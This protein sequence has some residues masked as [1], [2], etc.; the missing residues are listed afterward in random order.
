M[1]RRFQRQG[2]HAA[3]RKGNTADFCIL[4]LCAGIVHPIQSDAI[5]K[6][7]LVLLTFLRQVYV[8]IA[9]G[10]VYGV[11]PHS[12][13]LLLPC[14]VIVFFCLLGGHAIR[15]FIGVLHL[16]RDNLFIIFFPR[17]SFRIK[18]FIRCIEDIELSLR[19]E[20]NIIA[21]L[22]REIC[23]AV[24][25]I[26]GTT[27]DFTADGLRSSRVVDFQQQAIVKP[28]AEFIV[29]VPAVEG[30]VETIQRIKFPILRLR[31]WL[32]SRCRVRGGGCQGGC[33][34]GSAARGEQCR[35]GKKNSG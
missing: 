20:R 4:G 11:Q 35:C 6:I 2:F 19:R 7:Y 3:V 14:A 32:R 30:G 17:H 5:A 18:K 24:L 33:V 34:G 16:R 23:R 8:G 9:S 26:M 15:R 31:G 21:G 12:R 22:P 27:G 10:R 1:L 28:S 25:G 13:C 29:G